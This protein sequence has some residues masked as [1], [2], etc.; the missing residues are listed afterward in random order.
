MCDKNKLMN[1]VRQSKISKTFINAKYSDTLSLTFDEV[2]NSFC[3]AEKTKNDIKSIFIQYQNYINSKYEK[4]ES[5]SLNDTKNIGEDEFFKENNIFSFLK[6][7]KNFETSTLNNRLGV[8][9]RVIRIMIGN[10]LW[11]YINYTV[12][13]KKTKNEKLLSPSQKI[14]ILELINRSNSSDLLILFELVFD[15][16]FSIYQ[17]SRIKIKDIFFNQEIIE[18]YYKNSKK[19]RK[20][21]YEL[22]KVL[23]EHIN[24][25]KLNSSNYLLYNNFIETKYLNRY[26]YLNLKLSNLILKCEKIDDGTKD[27]L[28]KKMN[29]ER[30]GSKLNFLSLNLINE[31]I[32]ASN[33]I[34]VN[35]ENNDNYN[36]NI[37]DD[38]QYYKNHEDF[39]EIS[40]N[41]L[42][43]AENSFF[44]LFKE[45]E[46]ILAPKIKDNFDLFFVQSNNEEYSNITFT[47]ILKEINFESIYYRDILLE[48]LKQ[49]NIKFID[50]PIKELSFIGLNQFMKKIYIPPQLSEENI[51]KYKKLKLLTKEAYYHGLKLFKIFKNE[52]AI[53]TIQDIP[54]NTLLFEIAGELVSKEF[55]NKHKNE[56]SQKSFY[57]FNYCDGEEK[58]SSIYLLLRDF[59]NIAFFLKNCISNEPNVKICNFIDKENDSIILLCFSIKKLNK[60]EILFVNNKYSNLNL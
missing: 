45:K 6:N 42:F 59:G 9:R 12:Q 14:H 54:K 53:Q 50:N 37:K 11:D 3:W 34:L 36:Q 41:K 52:M 32:N 5:K 4:N 7:N 43:E 51:Q 10:P 1:L 47:I 48:A 17:V 27:A 2:I 46:D 16:G 44:S 29:I 31:P 22:L 21:N 55:L 57:Y 18:I 26:K 13:E 39:D 23:K 24:N 19:I 60:G 25:E 28:I 35:N 30:K 40:S 56:L 38:H 49:L 8:F 33:Q 20:I 58:N 15:L